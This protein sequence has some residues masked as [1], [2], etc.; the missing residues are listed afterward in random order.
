MQ[1][2]PSLV[3]QYLALYERYNTP[4]YQS[5][6]GEIIRLVKDVARTANKPKR[7][8][9]K[10]ITKIDVVGKFVLAFKMRLKSTIWVILDRSKRV[11]LSLLWNLP[12]TSTLMLLVNAC[13]A[14]K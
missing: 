13:W 4:A 9:G 2:S 11:S 14:S 3:R 6:I 12:T 1:I 10:G 8:R 5:R 7:C